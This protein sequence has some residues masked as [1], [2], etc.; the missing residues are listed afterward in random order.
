MV[1]SVAA[2]ISLLWRFRL[3]HN[4]TGEQHAVL[5]PPR[6]CLTADHTPSSH[7]G[8]SHSQDR[9]TS[10]SLST[11]FKSCLPDDK[12]LPGWRQFARLLAEMGARQLGASTKSTFSRTTQA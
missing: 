1:N 2:V 8:H 9:V 3:I 10:Y 5:P 12:A 11:E 6:Y 4:Q 7:D